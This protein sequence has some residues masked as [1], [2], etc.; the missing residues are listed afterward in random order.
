METQ[1]RLYI[2]VDFDGTVVKHEYPKV[3]ETIKGAVDVLKMLVA[4]KHNIILWTMRS[5][6]QLDDAVNWYK[7]NDIPLFGVN[8]NPTQVEWTESPKAYAE[9]YI[10]DAALGCPLCFNCVEGKNGVMHPVG[11]PFVDWVKVL[12]MLRAQGVIKNN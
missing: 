4:N 2:A 12:D 9:I 7:E 11:R 3:G 6:K 8:Y 10:D 5:G 1:K